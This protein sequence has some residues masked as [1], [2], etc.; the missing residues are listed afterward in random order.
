MRLSRVHAGDRGHDLTRCAI[1]AL[2]SILVDK[3]L[4]H[5]GAPLRIR[6]LACL[7]AKVLHKVFVGD[8]PDPETS[9]MYRA[10]S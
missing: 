7:M 4:L 3:S 2:Q 8:V 6:S 1:A 9:S 10:G 5:R